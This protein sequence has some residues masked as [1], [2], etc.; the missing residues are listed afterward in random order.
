MDTKEKNKE[1]TKTKK[2][3]KNRKDE[4]EDIFILLLIMLANIFYA[5]PLAFEASRAVPMNYIVYLI[6]PISIAVMSIIYGYKAGKDLKLSFATYIMLMPALII[7]QTNSN[8]ILYNISF[9]FVLAFCYFVL[10][11]VSTNFG[12]YIKTQE[13]LFTPKEKKK[14]KAKAKVMGKKEKVSKK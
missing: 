1:K 13:L 8:N 14:I 9:F 3:L 7:I 11:I 4:F 5:V 2:N 12:D 10:S 6:F